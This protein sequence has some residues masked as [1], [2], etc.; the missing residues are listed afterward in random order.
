MTDVACRIGSVRFSLAR[1]LPMLASRLLTLIALLGATGLA[2]CDSS[3]GDAATADARAA[4]EALIDARDGGGPGRSRGV[5]AT[6]NPAGAAQDSL[7]RLTS[8]LDAVAARGGFDARITSLQ[9]VTLSESGTT[10]LTVDLAAATG[11]IFALDRRCSRSGCDDSTTTGARL[12]AGA[13][14]GLVAP[15]GI[16][17]ARNRLVVADFGARNVKVFAARATG[18]VAPMFTVT[19]IGGNAARSVWDVA[20]DERRDRLFVAAT[21]GTVLVYDR[22]FRDRGAAGPTREITPSDAAGV[23]LSVNLHGIAFDA[24]TRTLVLSDIGSA[25]SATDG[26]LFTVANGDTASGAVAVRYRNAGGAQLGNPVDLVLDG[27]DAVVAE[28]SNDRLLRFADI[29][30]RTGT[31]AAAADDSAA[32]LKAESVTVGGGGYGGGGGGHGGGGGGS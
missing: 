23:K 17:I 12:V 21:D 5:Y 32:L 28:K 6:S 30:A 29:L 24:R 4:T 3:S 20:Y 15:K 22:F 19:A 13:A 18:D 2:A 16:V 7:V 9:N 8:A 1:L 25:A 26:Q 27:R 14:T 11:G 31:D 10:F